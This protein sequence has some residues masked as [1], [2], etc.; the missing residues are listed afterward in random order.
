[1]NLRWCR[2]AKLRSLENISIGYQL[3]SLHKQSKSILSYPVL[4]KMQT[5]MS[6]L[7]CLQQSLKYQ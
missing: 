3:Q 5:E 1:M 2:T 4:M 7:V 6:S